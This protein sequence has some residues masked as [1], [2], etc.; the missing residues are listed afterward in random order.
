MIRRWHLR[1]AVDKHAQHPVLAPPT[2]L[3]VND[4]ESGLEAVVRPAIAR[5]SIDLKYHV[6]N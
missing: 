6:F 3:D 4:F 5:N 2:S 1:W